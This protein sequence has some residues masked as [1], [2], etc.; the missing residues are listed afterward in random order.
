MPT[1]ERVSASSMTPS[2]MTFAKLLGSGPLAR[3]ALEATLAK[4]EGAAF[5][6]SARGTVLHANPAAQRKLRTHGTRLRARI[7]EAVT[8][9]SEE[10]SRLSAMVTPLRTASGP[11]F[12]LVVFSSRPAS[13]D[14]TTL[15]AMRWGLTR[16]QTAVL[17]L[18]AEGFS[19][20]TIAAKLDCAERTVETHLTAIFAKS[21]HASRSELLA[22]LARRKI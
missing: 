20:K 7:V 2:A 4:V 12:F 16:R 8:G 6:V 13:G 10:R 1:P 5:I 18:L 22:T 15:A 3:V 19:N 17:G 11:T 9:G 21:G 14:I